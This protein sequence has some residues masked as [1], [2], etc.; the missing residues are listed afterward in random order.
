MD[1][2]SDQ[3]QGGVNQFKQNN[4][5]LV[6]NS[7][8]L[9]LA[10]RDI[11]QCY[12]NKQDATYG[13]WQKTQD[14]VDAMNGKKKKQLAKYIGENITQQQFETDLKICFDALQKCWELAF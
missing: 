7:Q 9:I 8:I 5:S 2:P 10:K 1:Q 12:P 13:N 4:S 6:N 3:T 14:E 11:E